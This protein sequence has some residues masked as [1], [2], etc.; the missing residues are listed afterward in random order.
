MILGQLIKSWRKDHDLSLRAASHQI[1]LDLNALH[2]LE[3]GKSCDATN[4]VK[5]LAWAFKPMSKKSS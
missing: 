2:R 4:L 3:S 5:V 1:G